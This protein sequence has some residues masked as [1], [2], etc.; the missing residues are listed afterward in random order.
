MVM[1][2]MNTRTFNMLMAA[3]SILENSGPELTSA[4]DA[5]TVARKVL[6]VHDVAELVLA[7]LCIEVGSG[8][9]ITES[10]S[11]FDLVGFVVKKFGQQDDNDQ[12]NQRRGSLLALNHARVRF[13]HHGDLLDPST[14]YPL[15]DQALEVTDLLC[16]RGVGLPLRSIDALASVSHEAIVEWLRMA[17]GQIAAGEYKGALVSIARAVSSAFWDFDVQGVTV[18][19]PDS[20]GA[21]LL[22]GR[23][24]DPASFLEM[25]RF[26]PTLY[27]PFHETPEFDTRQ[28]GHEANWTEQNVQFCWST[29]LTIALRLQHAPIVPQARKFYDEFEDLITVTASGSVCYHFKGS[30]FS[31]VALAGEAI[32]CEAGQTFSGKAAG[33]YECRAPRD[34]EI[35]ESLS[36][37]TWIRLAPHSLSESLGAGIL[38]NTDELW[39]DSTKVQVTYQESALVKTRKKYL[40]DSSK[41]SEA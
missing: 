10:T 13:K 18:G 26:L 3:R 6:T 24:I 37:A 20:E 21:L 31:D 25:Q 32:E 27:S 40:S 11:F 34:T 29:A 41:A 14:T 9:K 19:K 4:S 8:F 28:Y 12:L 35:S 5:F 36:E 16:Q 17:E 30:R 38:F 15:V 1:K 23:G 2:P 7:A 22:S 33:F 39:F